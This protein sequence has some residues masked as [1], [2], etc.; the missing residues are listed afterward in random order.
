MTIY[1]DLLQNGITIDCHES[2]LYFPSTDKSKEILNRHPEVKHYT[3]FQ[4][5]IDTKL[6]IEIPFGY[7]PFWEK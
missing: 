1:E 3:M 7:I 5:S 6:W 4:D 2:D